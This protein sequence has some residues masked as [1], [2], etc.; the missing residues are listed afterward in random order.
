[1]HGWRLENYSVGR[2]SGKDGY[3]AFIWKEL[4]TE[5]WKGEEEC[6]LVTKISLCSLVMNAS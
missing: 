4:G 6:T 5:G 1:M 2:S 3:G